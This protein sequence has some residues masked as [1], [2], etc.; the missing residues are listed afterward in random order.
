VV[1]DAFA[2]YRGNDLVKLS[3]KPL[4]GTQEESRRGRM[5]EKSSQSRSSSA[6]RSDS[7]QDADD[8]VYEGPEM[9]AVKSVSTARSRVEFRSHLTD[10]QCLL[11]TPWLRGLDLQTKEWGTSTSPSDRLFVSNQDDSSLRRGR[12]FASHV[13]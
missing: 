2:Y 3:L 5:A 12:T 1:I 8:G 11:A 6:S 13:E 7:W 10:E 9:T 4:E